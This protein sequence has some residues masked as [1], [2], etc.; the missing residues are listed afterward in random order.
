MLNEC[1]LHAGSSILED[2]TTLWF[3]IQNFYGDIGS[4]YV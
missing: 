2:Y 1:V 4:K 3:H